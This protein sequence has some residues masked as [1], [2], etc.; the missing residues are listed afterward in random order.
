MNVFEWLGCSERKHVVQ[1]VKN[2]HEVPDKKK[3]P[4]YFAQRKKDGV[5]AIAIQHPDTG[6]V[7]FFGRTGK[8]LTSLKTFEQAIKSVMD[9]IGQYVII[10]ELCSDDCSL[11]VLSGIV[12]PN[13]TK[14]LTADQSEIVEKMYFAVHDMI[15]LDE[16]KEGVTKVPYCNRLQDMSV[17]LG[18]HISQLKFLKAIRST[19][20]FSETEAQAFAD[21]CIAEGEEG[22][23]LKDPDAGWLA[24]RKNEVAMKIVK[25]VDY[26]L[27]IVDFEEGKGKRSGTLAN[28]IVRWRV[29]GTMDGDVCHLCVDGR[30]TDEL[31]ATI[32]N[33][34]EEYRGR[35]VHVH[36]L[37]VGSKG[38]IRLPKVRAFRIDKT[39]ADL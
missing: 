10:T 32:W 4:A 6:E 39:V 28:L 35:I 37:C 12:N 2:Y 1:L 15:E 21:L 18:P 24:G 22:I 23:V 11:E 17:L 25:G 30:F 16:F 14:G 27:E 20:V 3:A 31:R 29:G 9:S 13:R 33:N 26:D 7:G 38:S 5:Y 36:G 19:T 34:R 8:R